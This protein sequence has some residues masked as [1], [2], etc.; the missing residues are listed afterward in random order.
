M[1]SRWCGGRAAR[2]FCGISADG[3]TLHGAGIHSRCI[4]DTAQQRLGQPMQKAQSLLPSRSRKYA[5]YI[6]GPRSPGAPS[7]TPP[8][9]RAFA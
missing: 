7:S 6:F 1:I 9:A 2:S 8:R 4:I 5:K 3:K